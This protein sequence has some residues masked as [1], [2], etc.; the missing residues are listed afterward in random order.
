[1]GGNIKATK[2]ELAEVR[3]LEDFDLTMFLSELR[4]H[5]WESAL[6]LLTMIRAA[7]KHLAGGEQ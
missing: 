6:R 2:E 7:N 3:S 4:D 1:M 5:G